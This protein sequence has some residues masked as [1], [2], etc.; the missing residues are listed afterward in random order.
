[1]PTTDWS[2]QDRR[3]RHLGMLGVGVLHVLIATAWLAARPPMPMSARGDDD[4]R[5]QWLWLSPPKPPVRTPAPPS[6]PAVKLVPDT[7]PRL[8]HAPRAMAP[9]T[10]PDPVPVE[11]TPAAETP[12]QPAPPEAA[13]AEPPPTS[14]ADLLSSARRMAGTVDKQLRKENH[15][16]LPALVDTPY[17]RFVAE[18]D[19]AHVAH[20]TGTP[21]ITEI[22]MPGTGEHI[23]KVSNGST[24]YCIRMPS[25]GMGIDQYEKARQGKVVNCPR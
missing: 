17:K 22:T 14:A 18:M 6:K 8:P 9:V 16:P 24:S 12:A 19:A 3:H 21:T 10:V 7:A 5:I 13:A 25:P 4:R 1:M 23:T 11:T 2:T 20:W 15:Q